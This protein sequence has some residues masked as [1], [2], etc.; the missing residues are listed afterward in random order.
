MKLTLKK[1][2]SMGEGGPPISELVFREEVVAGDL[3]GVKLSALKDPSF[4]DMLKIAGR[5]CAQT[6]NTM[7]RLS[8]DD[9]AD[10]IGLVAGFLAGSPATG[11]TV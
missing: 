3:R 1:P 7:A 4:D 5:L 2:V 6:E 10:V 11:T 8:V 9:A